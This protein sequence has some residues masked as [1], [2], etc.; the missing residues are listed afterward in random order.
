MGIVA[1]DDST[2]TVTETVTETTTVQNNV[3]TLVRVDKELTFGM[4]EPPT[5]TNAL[6]YLKMKDGGTP[7]DRLIN[8]KKPISFV[9]LAPPYGNVVPMLASGSI[10]ADDCVFGNNGSTCDYTVDL[11][12]TLTWSDGEVIDADDVVYTKTLADLIS[13]EFPVI[14]KVNAT[15]VIVHIDTSTTNEKPGYCAWFGVFVSRSIL[16]HH[17]WSEKVNEVSDPS[18]L[19]TIDDSDM[20]HFAPYV[21]FDAKRENFNHVPQILRVSPYHSLVTLKNNDLYYS[22]MSSNV[23]KYLTRASRSN[24]GTIFS[25]SNEWVI[26]S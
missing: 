8:F 5:V 11:R 26:P 25:T 12:T 24:T 21:V 13:I 2:D 7:Q 4:A 17:Y 23:T 3:T 14:T 22:L 20:P 16:P 19:L 10:D 6:A 9:D 15:R 1:S 18:E